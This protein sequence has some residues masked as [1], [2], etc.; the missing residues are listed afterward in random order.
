MTPGQLERLLRVVFALN[1][2]KD[3]DPT[4]FQGFQCLI[5]FTGKKLYPIFMISP[6]QNDS[7]LLLYVQGM[8]MEGKC[9]DEPWMAADQAMLFLMELAMEETTSWTLTPLSN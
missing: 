2:L 5:T 7:V 4:A 3:G 1:I 6:N 9:R 8:E